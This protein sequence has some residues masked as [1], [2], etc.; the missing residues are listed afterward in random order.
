MSTT[1]AEII[2]KA[3]IDSLEKEYDCFLKVEVMK[4]LKDLESILN[5]CASKYPMALPNNVFEHK[6]PPDVEKYVLS[7]PSTTPTDQVKVVV[8][9]T[10]DAITHADI[11]L[12]LPKLGS[13]KD[14]YQNTNIRED[15]PWRLQQIQDS[16]NH[17]SYAIDAFN[18]VENDYAFKSAK[19]LECYLNRIS[20]FLLKSRA[21]LIN[22]R[23]RT[24]EELQKN[25][26]VKG[27]Q[28]PVPS[29]LALSFYVQN[30]RLIFAVYHIITEKGVSKFN[31]YQAECVIP[32]INDV[33]L[34]LTVGL[35]TAQQLKDKI[36][37]FQQYQDLQIST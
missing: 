32:W 3:E 7:V 35:Q 30:W 13:S 26:N 18:A 34:L 21:A 1:T 25:K 33:L 36:H 22:P 24:L 4:V 11:N 6:S 17:L 37:V 19:E 5:K 29:D 15:H 10:G 9:V 8:T 27:F 20:S 14:L 2:E 16:G 28:P 23:K 12:K 31:R